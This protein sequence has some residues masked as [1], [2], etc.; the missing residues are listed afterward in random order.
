MKYSFTY[1]YVLSQGEDNIPEIVC[2]TK[3]KK[4]NEY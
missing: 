1:Y 2:H 4:T 3:N